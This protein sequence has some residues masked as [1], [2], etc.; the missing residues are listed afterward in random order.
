MKN[1]FNQLKT[2]YKFIAIRTVI[3]VLIAFLFIF[4]GRIIGLA[5]EKTN[6]CRDYKGSNFIT[7]NLKKNFIYSGNG[8]IG[9]LEF[10]NYS[11]EDNSTGIIYT[12]VIE[13][14]GIDFSDNNKTI[15]ISYDGSKIPKGSLK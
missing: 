4:K 11:I 1:F 2:K 10:G 7:G 8:E 14:L 15:L 6:Y 13:D 9:G 3:I 5:I 12:V